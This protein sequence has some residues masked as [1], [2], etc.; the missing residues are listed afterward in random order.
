MTRTTRETATGWFSALTSGDADRALGYL[1]DDIE[2]VNYTPVPGYNDRMPWIG[3]YHGP[4]A[5]LDSLKVFLDMVDVGTEKLVDLIVEGDQAIGILH[6]KSVVK[7]TGQA[8]EIEFIQHLTVRDG[9]IVRWKSY[10]DPS[11]ILRAIDGRAA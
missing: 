5:V 2:W 6:E 8:F 10:T 9:K 3:T 7:E 1:A 4:A 11:Q